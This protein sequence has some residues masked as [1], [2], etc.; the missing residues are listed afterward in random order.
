MDLS[1]VERELKAVVRK[2]QWDRWYD[3][4]PADLREKLSL[5]D[6]KR[7]GECFKTAFHVDG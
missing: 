7:L 3:S 6:F 1:K 4:L 5:R 2:D